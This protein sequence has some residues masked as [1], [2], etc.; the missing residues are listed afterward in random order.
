MLDLKRLRVLQAVAREGS[1]S[2][3][4]RV[5]DYT[6]PAVGHHIRKLEAEIGTPLVLRR[7]RGV[8]LTEAGEALA[9]RADLLLAAAA[10]AADEVQSLAGL[11]RGRVR[12]VAFPT[13][14]ATL[15]PPAL[16][17]L[18]A[19][20]PGLDVTL[21]EAEPPES[22][23]LVVKGE[24]DVAIAFEHDAQPAHDTDV[25]LERVD[26]LR[27]EQLAVLPPDHPLAQAH[28]VGLDELQDEIWIAGCP[29]CRGLLLHLTQQIGYEPRIDVATDDYVAVQGMVAAGLGVALLPKLVLD[30]VHR[31]DVALVPLARPAHRTIYATAL[32]GARAVPP[33]R[34]LL[35]ALGGRTLVG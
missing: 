23:E 1:L 28:A 7:G 33:V 24:A 8:V 12:L 19:E 17:R 20:H 30:V 34:A 9:A 27:D 26:L 11:K 15:V 10:T 29:R 22:V 16:A 4:A 6:Q 31:E 5:L 25:G 3:A 14:N 21:T 32:A 18:R 13:A 2:G 35:D